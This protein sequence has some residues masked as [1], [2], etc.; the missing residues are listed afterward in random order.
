MYD[1]IAGH[2]EFSKTVAMKMYLN[3]ND[4]EIENNW[5]E[6]EKDM[7]RQKLIEA[8]AEK[9]AEREVTKWEEE[10]NQKDEAEKQAGEDDE[11]SST[12]DAVEDAVDTE[13][14]QTTQQ[15]IQ[16]QQTPAQTQAPQSQSDVSQTPQKQPTQDDSDVI[17][18]P[19]FI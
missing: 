2:D 18:Q 19:D 13:K 1:A 3:M 12:D 7:M 4:A 8:K 15:P 14:I 16:T 10:L 11:Y 6:M 9:L 17:K 5:V